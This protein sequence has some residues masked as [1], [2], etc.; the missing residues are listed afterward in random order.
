MRKNATRAKKHGLQPKR[1][2]KKRLKTAKGPE[3]TQ[4]VQTV[5]GEPRTAG[6]K[7][8]GRKGRKG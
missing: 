1:E 3:T 2:V 5:A 8:P 6:K 7:F 4:S